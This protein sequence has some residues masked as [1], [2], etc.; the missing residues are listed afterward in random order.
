[1]RATQADQALLWSKEVCERE[2]VKTSWTRNK[3]QNFSPELAQTNFG[4][5]SEQ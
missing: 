2:E 3:R 5:L 4:G 1:M